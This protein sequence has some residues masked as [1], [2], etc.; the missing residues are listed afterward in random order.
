MRTRAVA[1]PTLPRDDEVDTIVDDTQER[2]PTLIGVPVPV[3][4]RVT[5]DLDTTLRHPAESRFLIRAGFDAGAPTDIIA[6]S[7][8][9]GET[10]VI[11]PEWAARNYIV[12]VS[13][14]EAAVPLQRRFMAWRPIP[15]TEADT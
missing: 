7:I 3:S 5:Q 11:G 4:R 8:A 13:L 10:W 15:T 14:S 2:E 12:S 6:D 1:V 9:A